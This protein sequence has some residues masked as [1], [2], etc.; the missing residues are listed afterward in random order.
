[1]AEKN[2]IESPSVLSFDRKLEPSDALMFSGNWKDISNPDNW[3][4]IELIER[5]NRGVKSNF[6]TE[7]LENE[8][9]LQKQIEEPNPVWGDDAALPHNHDTLKVS[10]TLRAVGDLDKPSA[11]NKSSYQGRLTEVI[12]EYAQQPT[13]RELAIR[14]ANNIANSRFLWRNRVGAE[15]IKV[16]VSA[17]GFENP[18]E[19]DSY[20][21]PLNKV[22]HE[23]D[24]ITQLADLIASGFSGNNYAFMEIDAFVK[25]GA[26]QRIWPSQEMRMNIPKGEKSRHLFQLNGCAA[27]HT[28]KIGNA[29]RTIDDWYAPDAQP[30]A[31][32]PY[33]SVTHRGMAFRASKNDFSTLAEKWIIKKQEINEVEKHFIMAVLIRGGVFSSKD[34]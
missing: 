22:N 13:F 7:V 8:E 3:Q 17:P 34:E 21:Y 32:E 11:C 27:I 26:G 31:V 5:R 12:A 24:K 15:E 18:V 19:F 14:Y 6:K 2:E 1:M 23:D 20:K 29:L 33:G 16:I 10:F 30:I 25:L 28:Q 4:I 9:E